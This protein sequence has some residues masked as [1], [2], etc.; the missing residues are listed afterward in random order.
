MSNR[1]SGGHPLRGV[2]IGTGYGE[3]EQEEREREGERRRG[4]RVLWCSVY[5]RLCLYGWVG[6][7]GCTLQGE[8]RHGVLYGD[9]LDCVCV[10]VCI[11]RYGDRVR[12]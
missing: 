6:G 9:R 7:W 4:Q 5:V 8:G 3:S 12:Q 1:G 11:V 10:C 2:V